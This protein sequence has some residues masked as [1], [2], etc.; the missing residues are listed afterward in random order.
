MWIHLE[1]EGN[2]EKIFV[3]IKNI[4]DYNY[5]IRVKLHKTLV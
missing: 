1:T 5:T 2:L 4:T 3:L